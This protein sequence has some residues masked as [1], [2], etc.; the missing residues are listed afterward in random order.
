M[1]ERLIDQDARDRIRDVLD[2]N[3]VVSAGAGAGKTF[4]LVERMVEV[5]RS[6]KVDV[7]HLA[8][9]TFTRKAA[10][11]MRGRFY[12]G[13][14]EAANTE[15]D[16]T[17]NDRL[18]HALAHVDQCFIGTI[19]SFCARLLRERPLD[20]KLPPDFQEVDERV[21]AVHRRQA[22]DD[23][24]HERFSVDDPRLSELDAVGLRTE[25][26]YGFFERRCQFSDLPLRPTRTIDVDLV[27]PGKALVDWILDARRYVPDPLYEPPDQFQ[28]RLIYASNFI[29]HYGLR[30]DANRVH[31]FSRFSLKNTGIVLRKWSPHETEARM[32]R[33]EGFAGIRD[34]VVEPTLARW[35]QAVYPQAADLVDDAAAYYKEVRRTLGILS[36]QD[37]LERAADLLRNKPDVRRALARRYR[38]LFVDEFQDTDPIQAEIITRLTAENESADWRGCRPRP[39]SLF[40]V[41]DEKQSIYRFRRADIDTFRQVS[42]QIV[43]SGGEAVSLTTSFRSVGTLCGWINNAFE[44]LFGG[45]EA[46]FQAD[47]APL[48][49]VRDPGALDQ[50][51]YTLS[52]AAV[53]YH[54]RTDIAEAEADRVARFIG[55]CVDGDPP[56]D[57]GRPLHPQD[58]LI[59]T[60]TT[61][62]LDVFARALE[63][64]GLPFDVAGSGRL[65]ES[66]EIGRVLELLE[67]VHR[68]DDA[69]SLVG[70]LR[71]PFV[72][73]GDDELY[74]F[75]KAGGAFNY[76]IPVPNARG[77][78]SRERIVR[79]FDRL[80]Q[81]KYDLEN[82]PPAVALERI[83][84]D[85]Q[86]LPFVASLE[87]GS[88]RAGNLIRLIAIFRAWESEG[89]NWGA[90]LEELRDL[91]RDPKFKVE[92]MTLESGGDSAVR[93]MNLHQAKGLQAPV[94][95]L[96]DGY[97]TSHRRHGPAFHVSR[98]G[99][100]PYLALPVTRPLG[101]HVI[102]TVA[103][104]TGW[105]DD[106]TREQ[107]FLDAEEKR[108]IYVGATRAKDLLVVAQYK[109]NM[110]NGPWAPLYPYLASA[111]ELPDIS[112]KPD[113]LST[114]D[115]IDVEAAN[116][117][118]EDRWRILK[119]A[120]HTLITPSEAEPPDHPEESPLPPGYGADYGTLVHNLLQQCIED[121][122]PEKPS[123]L[124]LALA[125][126]A[127]IGPEEGAAALETLARF[128]S[129]D[130]L[131]E[132]RSSPD[133]YTEVD[134]AA[135]ESLL[136]KTSILRGR[137]DLVYRVKGGW[138]IVDF[139]TER[140]RT[141]S[142]Q[143]ALVRH[144]RNQVRAYSRT[145]RQLCGQNVVEAGI[146]S[147]ETGTWL[148]ITG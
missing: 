123:K 121:R 122:L 70:Y 78:E 7:E 42:E 39:G 102:E 12:M 59:L 37:L 126:K 127:S 21:E 113:A 58:F 13:L 145:W 52:S 20:A 41:G 25:D 57:L 89:K 44:P 24:F 114:D 104:P 66:E 120:S 36:F 46:R 62:A 87:M 125:K 45:D 90:C 9:I 26:L 83:L 141:P 92:E 88:S 94:V 31:L 134:F 96:V 48:H 53:P 116:R 68:P 117:N 5:V 140:V 2:R 18:R 77:A 11:E 103:Q 143:A 84:D 55:A 38:V 34:T 147:T 60:R 128:S 65:G 131:K 1:A 74:A 14:R 4:K 35:R 40:L 72:G 105:S 93:L 98:S 86:A 17:R 133:S 132:V 148:P 10:G 82:R 106:E 69:L 95:F 146:W 29:E 112:R 110:D 32:I 8:A 30:T 75:R 3:I 76:N 107:S 101:E 80:R 28:T 73:L 64:E 33:D 99:K 135:P 124:V 51:V 81:A 119:H 130:L 144:Y 15:T 61:G 142:E 47:F 139:K 111:P 136:G 100:F 108:L 91:V 138:T 54:R 71:G 129:S 19:H 79:A 6:G 43:A 67:A 97:D 63:Q 115:N 109:G 118:R 23:F 27:A 49:P 50:H 137:I 56:L 85:L 22:W 16:P